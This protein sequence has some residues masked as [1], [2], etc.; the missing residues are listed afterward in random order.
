VKKHC[1]ILAALLT[2]AVSAADAADQSSAWAAMTNFNVTQTMHGQPGI[3]KTRVESG[4]GGDARI[5]I[6]ISDGKQQTKGTI[7]LISGRWMVTQGLTLQAGSEIDLMDIAALNSQ[8][9]RALLQA[10]VPQGP[11]EAGKE[12]RILVTELN[13]PIQVSTTS[14]SGEYGV[15][16][17]L[18]GTVRESA[19]AERTEYQLDFTSTTDG[20]KA[21]M[22][23]E[24][25]VSRA[26]PPF[27]VPDSTLLTGWKVHKIGPYQEPV[28]GG[29]TKFDYGARPEGASVA[30]V[31]ELRS[32]K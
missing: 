28:P 26:N 31:G 9:V 24:G 7:L 15:P 17:T 20:T 8:L 25:D 1:A 5:V 4:N 23:L 3:V 10:A 11:P 32:A 12:R 16:W 14:A 6:D 29:G 13:H 18:A 22:H 30:T 27:V 19:E 2:A 21:T